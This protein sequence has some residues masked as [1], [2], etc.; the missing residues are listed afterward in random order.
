MVKGSVN[1]MQRN[2]ITANK[3]AEHSISWTDIALSRCEK[4]RAF[5]D[6]AQRLHRI[7]K[8]K[9]VPGWCKWCML[10]LQEGNLN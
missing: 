2:L 10:P 3:Y 7:K 4:R 5:I 8:R 1:A 6:G 9:W